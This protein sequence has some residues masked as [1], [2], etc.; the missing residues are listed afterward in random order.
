ML[1]SPRISVVR[2]GEIKAQISEMLHRIF[3]F[4]LRTR[5]RTPVF[6]P[7]KSHGQRSLAGLHGVAK[8][9]GTT[10]P[11]NNDSNKGTFIHKLER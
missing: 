10:Y 8:M 5:Q 3:F 4:F 11:L 6:L 2:A 9:L 7:G 1:R